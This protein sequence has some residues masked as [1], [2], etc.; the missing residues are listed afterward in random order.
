VAGRLNDLNRHYHVI[1]ERTWAEV[2]LRLQSARSL[3]VDEAQGGTPLD[4][5]RM[6]LA[7][8]GTM[9][10]SDELKW[11]G[12]RSF[13]AGFTLLAMLLKGLVVEAR[14]TAARLRGHYDTAPIS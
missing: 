13:R 8:R 2:G 6:K 12:R 14:H 3:L 9:F 5:R 11:P 10:D 4:P 1:D 7:N